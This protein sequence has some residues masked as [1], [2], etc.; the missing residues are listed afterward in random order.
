MCTTE[1]L[2]Y[3]GPQDMSI[4][5][6]KKVAEELFPT[7]LELHPTNIGEPL[8]SPWF[9]K[10]VTTMK[11]YGVMLDLTTNGTLITKEIAD[12]I[13]P[14]LSDIKISFDGAEK[15]TFENIRQGAVFDMVCENI[16]QI[17]QM[18]DQKKTANYPTV[19]LQMTLMKKN[20][21]QLPAVMNL[22]Y[23]L[24][25]DR[26]KAYHLFSNSP[27]MDQEIT[28]EG[29]DEIL[30]EAYNTGKGEG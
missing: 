6:F 18:R 3:E 26:V 13:L 20:I 21:H 24:G 4:D 10:M 7:L 8:C 25:A 28:I 30:K 16:R 11:H 22:A 17:V 15:E 12:L 19:S 1:R 9:K 23:Q 14:V 5:I 2:N 27:D 29:S